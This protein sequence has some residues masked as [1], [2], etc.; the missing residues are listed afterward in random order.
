MMHV[1]AVKK[2]KK[3]SEFVIYSYLKDSSFI[4]VKRD[5]SFSTRYVKGVGPFFNRRYMKG[6]PFL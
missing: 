4:S 3:C 6:V 5:A 1:I 2:L